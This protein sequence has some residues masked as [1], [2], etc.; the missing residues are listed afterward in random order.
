MNVRPLL[1]LS[2]SAKGDFAHLDH[3]EHESD[4][5]IVGLDPGSLS[6]DNLNKAFRVLKSE[7]PYE[8]KRDRTSPPSL[9]APHTSMFQQA[10]A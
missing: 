8:G 7:P 2:L 9:I 1:L 6:Y 10:P 3:S 5:V 4:S